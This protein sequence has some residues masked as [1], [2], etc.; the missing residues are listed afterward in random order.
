[1]A[2]SSI[3][4]E[5]KRLKALESRQGFSSAWCVCLPRDPHRSTV[6][7]SIQSIASAFFI[8]LPGTKCKEK[9]EGGG[10]GGRNGK[11]ERTFEKKKFRRSVSRLSRGKHDAIETGRSPQEQKLCHRLVLC[12]SFCVLTPWSSISIFVQ[13]SPSIIRNNV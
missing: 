9:K 10:G 4:N 6:F 3:K 2:F 5:A 13:S 11:K 12:F 8:V 1:M 7:I